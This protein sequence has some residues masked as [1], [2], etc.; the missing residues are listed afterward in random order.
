M[1]EAFLRI[2]NTSFEALNFTLRVW[3]YHFGC[4]LCALKDPYDACWQLFW[5]MA[6]NQLDVIE[7]I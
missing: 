3:V 4:A 6:L 7:E 5:N 2:N 1:L